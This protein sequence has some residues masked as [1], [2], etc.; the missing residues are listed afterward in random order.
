[1]FFSEWTRPFCGFFT[2]YVCVERRRRTRW[3]RCRH[4]SHRA[5]GLAVV[6]GLVVVGCLA[7][8]DNRHNHCKPNPQDLRQSRA[9]RFCEVIE[10]CEG[11][12]EID[13][14]GRRKKG[15]RNPTG[16]GIMEEEHLTKRKDSIMGHFASKDAYK[17]LTD[18]INWFTQGA[19]VSETL[20][21]IL[22]VLY[23]ED[24]AKRVA[25]LPVRPFTAKC[26]SSSCRLRWR[27]SL[28]SR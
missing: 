22:Q 11:N 16:G 1:M 14:G 19:P 5:G 6:G 9:K 7:A 2:R 23:T 21:Q 20:Y 15:Y 10:G 26:G 24:E 28:S 27:G 13:G 3:H 12:G 17:N 25:L 8:G 18:R 4:W